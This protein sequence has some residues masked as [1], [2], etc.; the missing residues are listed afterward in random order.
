VAQAPPNSGRHNVNSFRT[1]SGP[2]TGRFEPFEI[3]G[4]RPH[5]QLFLE[6]RKQD[7]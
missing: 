2:E 6:T 7:Y 1:V 5:L 4:L 3:A